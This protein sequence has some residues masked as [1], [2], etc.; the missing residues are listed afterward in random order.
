M[1]LASVTWA[2][3]LVAA[4]DVATVA[5][6][7]PYR[8]FVPHAA[9]DLR[10]SMIYLLAAVVTVPYVA[11]IRLVAFPRA[12]FR[13][14]VEGTVAERSPPRR[15]SM[16]RRPR[17]GDKRSPAQEY[18]GTAGVTGCGTRG[19]TTGALLMR[20]ADAV[21][22]LGDQ[23]DAGTPFLLGGAAPC[24]RHRA[25]RGTHGAASHRW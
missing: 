20:F 8:L 6:D 3:G 11:L 16:L 22:E 5:Y 25:P 21:A 7:G 24:S 4:A 19:G 2:A 1:Q 13:P 14:A 12:G 15:L 23:G 18:P 10:W 9:G 17:P